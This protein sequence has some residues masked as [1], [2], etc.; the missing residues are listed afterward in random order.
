MSGPSFR[1]P[2][3]RGGGDGPNHHDSD[4]A[5]DPNRDNTHDNNDSPSL[6]DMILNQVTVLQDLIKEHNALG[7]SVLK[8][9]RLNFGDEGDAPSKGKAVVT[10]D[11]DVRKNKGK[12]VVT[13]DE[14]LHKPYKESFRPP[15][16]QR[17][18][19]YSGQKYTSP[20]TLKLYDGSTDPDDHLTRF[21]G[22]GQQG[23][24]PM[25]VWFRMFQQTLDGV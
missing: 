21:S 12:A 2:L 4:T 18:V 24:W 22:A 16:T 5:E 20:N 19:Q 6:Q 13:P 11:D 9:I 7:G 10:T 23:E 17:I 8:P 14:E 1:T 25:P 3:D 15:F